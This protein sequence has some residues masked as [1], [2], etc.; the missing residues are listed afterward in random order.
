MF[1]IKNYVKPVTLEEAYEWNQKR[2]NAI[3]G[4]TLWLRMG[5]RD[6][7]TA[8]DLSDLG[9]S[10]IEENDDSFSIGSMV[11]LRQLETNQQLHSYFDNAIAKSVANIVG[12][13]FRNV[14]TVG[15][16]IFGRF[17]FSDLLTCFLALDTKVELFKGGIIPLST[18]VT[19]PYNRDI[20][21]R[22]IIKKE[23]RNVSYL[24]QRNSK[25]DFPVLACAVSKAKGQWN[26]VLGGRPNRAQLVCDTDHLLGEIPNRE[27]IETFISYVQA[28]VRFGTNMRASETYRKHLSGILITRGMNEILNN[29][30]VTKNSERTE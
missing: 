3:L 1:T 19:M 13:Q 26:V 18:F 14:A 20:L 10:K 28:Q 22:I 9:L 16:S 11:T 23:D 2:N 5:K 29:N 25:T 4:G 30:S 21:V 27:E 7:A 8:I 17:G 12:V 6:I 15:G 24:T